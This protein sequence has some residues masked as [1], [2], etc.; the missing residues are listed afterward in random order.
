MKEFLQEVTEALSRS[1]EDFLCWVFPPKMEAY[2]I[3]G[4]GLGP[5]NEEAR[6]REQA[7]TDAAVTRRV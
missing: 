5:L 7:R 2:L 1:F 4:V 6:Q 3:R